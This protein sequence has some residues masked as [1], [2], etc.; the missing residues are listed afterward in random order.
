[1]DDVGTTAADRV[2]KTVSNSI[3]P[4]ASAIIL[5]VVGGAFLA[6]AFVGASSDARESMVSG[7]FPRSLLGLPLLEG[8][9]DQ[10]H[11]GVHLK[12]GVFVIL[13]V[14][15]IVALLVWAVNGWRRRRSD[16]A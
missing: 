5:W 16:P 6:A 8:F 15:V 11:F 12:S 3:A 7:V 9:R 1:M 10:D 2:K 14:P 13:V 4:M